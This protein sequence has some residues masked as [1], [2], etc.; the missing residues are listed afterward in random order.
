VRAVRS[1][2]RVR[3]A[4]DTHP[5]VGKTGDYRAPTVPGEP[6]IALPCALDARVK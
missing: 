2:G 6:N 4:I 5:A 3:A 1:K